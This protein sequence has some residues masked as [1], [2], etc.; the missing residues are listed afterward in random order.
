M[1]DDS[2]RTEMLQ[3]NSLLT[4][5][6]Q[7]G[8]VRF[9]AVRLGGAAICHCRMCQKAFGGFFGPLVSGY[10]V[11]WTRHEPTYFQSSNKFRR[12]F[13]AQ[14]GTPLT[15]EA[16][17]RID[18]DPIELAIGALDHP[19][20]A[21]PTRQVNLTDR[22]PFFAS[23]PDLPA[24]AADDAAWLETMTDLVSYQHPDHDTSFWPPSEGFP[25]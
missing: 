18:T 10:G 7:C 2:P 15:Y 9:Q 3:D 1:S 13:C 22:L 23:L 12:G 4:G 16:L 25:S 20:L 11:V 5:G 17:D 24:R 21:A 8:A 19:T 14:C 6:C